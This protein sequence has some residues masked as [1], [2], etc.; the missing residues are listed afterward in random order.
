MKSGFLIRNGFNLL[1]RKRVV[2]QFDQ[3]PLSATH[4]SWKKRWNLVK[5]GLNR[6]FPI[7][8]TMGR[9][10]MAHISPSNLCDLNCRICPSKDETTKAR[11]L[12]P[13]ETFR[14]FVDEAGDTLLYMILWS[15]GEPILNPELARMVR[16][17]TDR[18]ILTVT[19]TNLNRLS[20]AQAM[21]LIQSGLSALI[22][23]VDGTKKESYLAQRRGGDFDRVLK[24]IRT[25][26]AAKKTNGGAGPILNMRMVVSRE[27]EEE[28]DEFRQLAMKLGVD[29]VSYKAFSTRQDGT[30][31]P[32]KDQQFAPKG[33]RFKWYRYTRGFETERNSGKYWCRF[34][35][36]KPT[37]F[38]DGEII[39]CE[40]DLHYQHP[41]G[42]INEQHFDKIWFSQKAEDFRHRFQA[43]R[44]QFGFCKNCVYD[45]R[46]F[47]GCVLSAEF[48]NAAE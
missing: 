4:L 36:T 47:D 42:N 37:L 20:D 6:L 23:A 1:F 46:T 39:S 22:I 24:N 38:P 16:Y 26:V 2:F 18:N 21:E 45:Y 28:V 33:D 12:L 15:W 19:S 34:P 29:M 31:D 35:W 11:M 7:A 48:L 30:A 44:D 14:K 8:R 13:F 43:N 3:I 5:I 27:N 25:L 32:E 40:F 9:P 17:A 41:F 10:Y